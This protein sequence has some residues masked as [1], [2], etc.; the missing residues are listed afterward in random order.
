VDVKLKY[1]NTMFK[2]LALFLVFVF[3]VFVSGAQKTIS[4]IV[5]EEIKTKN[6]TV[7]IMRTSHL[8]KGKIISG[9]I[10]FDTET[11]NP[12][13]DHKR[14]RVLGGLAFQL[15]N[16]FIPENGVFTASLPDSETT[17]L[18]VFSENGKLIED[19]LLE[20]S[21]PAENLDLDVPKILRAGNIEKIT[22]NFSGDITEAAV[23]VNDKSLN[24]VAGNESE[25]F[26]ETTGV[27]PGKQQLS[28]DY[29]K[30]KASQEVNVV[31]YTLEAGR[32][33]LNRG[34]STYLDVKITGLE[35]VKESL[36]L[37]IKN[38][39]V[40]T[41]SIEGGDVQLIQIIPEEVAET[42]MWE[43]R[44]D[45]QSIAR[46]SFSV[47]T[48]LTVLE[49]EE[50]KPED[51]AKYV[52]E[53]VDFKEE[54][55]NIWKN[56]ELVGAKAKIYSDALLQV[57]DENE[58]KPDQ[59]E[60][61]IGEQP[62]F[63]F[64]MKIAD[65][66][67]DED[68]REKIIRE[69]RDNIRATGSWSADS[70]FYE[71]EGGLAQNPTSVSAFFNNGVIGGFASGYAKASIATRD[72]YGKRTSE[73]VTSTEQLTVEI[74]TFSV[75][76]MEVIPKPGWNSFVAGS[77]YVKLFASSSAFDAVAGNAENSLTYAKAIKFAG[78]VALKYLASGSK[79]SFSDYAKDEISGELQ[80]RLEDEAIRQI[81]EMA[82][83]YLD[84]YSRQYG[85][86]IEEIAG[87]V[88]SPPDLEEMLE[89]FLGFEI[90]TLDELLD[91]GIDAALNLLLVSNTYCTANGGIVVKIDNA[92]ESGFV[93]SRAHY[94]RKELEDNAV[95][96]TSAKTARFY[97]SNVRPNSIT[98]E[99]KGIASMMARARGNGQ[100]DAY[101][102]STQIQALVGV[103]RGPAGQFEYTIEL[104]INDFQNDVEHLQ[105]LGEL[106]VNNYK[107]Q[108]KAKI[109]D[110]L[111]YHSSHLEWKNVVEEFVKELS[112]E[113]FW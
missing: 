19:I 12:K 50:T 8:P 34:E 9:T 29:D 54:V 7:K 75:V 76:Q 100:A 94:A 59:C 53:A 38:Q 40:G 26:F 11:K 63:Q 101:L 22:G 107:N 106:V 111:D 36:Q 82:E 37:E 108:L 102:E 89:R 84:D 93:Y 73:W 35:D 69:A 99:T 92:S 4:G 95:S 48:D 110:E 20:L 60:Y 85:K 105:D 112:Q 44:F 61:Q 70:T 49:E 25:L 13:K 79:E 39:S 109:K 41:I 65:S 91:E 14:L 87:D 21:E 6:G 17:S 88:I 18:K 30:I 83:Q 10:V 32:L 1:F 103:C 68:D 97:V 71:Q 96:Q 51:A 98:I 24:V 31:D 2:T 33:N 74:D 56:M 67:K 16:E 52:E 66:W 42:A 46:G 64:K 58:E 23:A 72:E 62:G 15:G 5:T 55:L 77:S 3:I 113:N 90:P 104:I 47:S 78:A 28:L 27:E 43:K 81:S 86:T 80:G 45:I 57:K